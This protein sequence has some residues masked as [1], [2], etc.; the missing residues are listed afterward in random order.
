MSNARSLPLV[1]PFLVLLGSASVALA[2]TPWPPIVLT[3]QVLPGV[4]QFAI[5]R[6]QTG[7]LS[8]VYC[9]AD[10]TTIRYRVL[11]ETGTWSAPETVNTG[12]GPQTADLAIDLDPAGVP[13]VFWLQ[14]DSVYHPIL[15][16]VRQTNG[17]WSQGIVGPHGSLFAAKIGAD[18]QLRLITGEWDLIY[19]HGPVEGTLTIDEIL[20]DGER[21]RDLDLALDTA[22]QPIVAVAQTYYGGYQMA[23]LVYNDGAQWQQ[24]SL[25]YAW[26]LCNEP[27][28]IAMGAAIHV[29]TCRKYTRLSSPTADVNWLA[30]WQDDMVIDEHD[31]LYFTAGGWGDMTL[32]S[33]AADSS[34]AALAVDSRPCPGGDCP[35]FTTSQVLYDRGLVLVAYLDEAWG[36][37]VKGYVMDALRCSFSG[38]VGLTLTSSGSGVGTV[39][40]EPAGT[41]CGADTWGYPA[42]T[43][44]TL[45]PAPGT[46]SA[47]RTWAGDCAGSAGACTLTLEAGLRKEVTAEFSWFPD[48]L[49]HPRSWR[50]L[51]EQ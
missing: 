17:D 27:I 25:A 24:R 46:N 35:H 22:G 39:T 9:G 51:P 43:A 50:H 13:H 3:A 48:E 7:R 42:G 12:T 19:A 30:S 15:H 37:R 45:K 26:G 29:N 41:A 11:S 44:V 47:F 49:Q 5:T 40:R 10:C 21:I 20:L 38:L 8:L 34:S 36:L 18:G 16:A 2:A 4:G 23:K 14:V 31:V 32:G 1:L 6:S 28:Q 33:I